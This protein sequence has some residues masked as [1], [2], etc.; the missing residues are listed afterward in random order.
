MYGI[1]LETRIP[2]FGPEFRRLEWLETRTCFLKPKGRSVSLDISAAAAVTGDLRELFSLLPPTSFLQ[3][4]PSGVLP[5]PSS[6]P[7]RARPH[8]LTSS[9][10]DQ[11][12]GR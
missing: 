10:P 11:N 8:P 9:L 12:L 7:D 3:R 2:E 6:W 4:P 1:G 5:R